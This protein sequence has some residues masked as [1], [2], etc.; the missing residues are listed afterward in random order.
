MTEG[1]TGRQSDSDIE[2]ERKRGDREGHRGGDRER[3]GE[4]EK[5]TAHKMLHCKSNI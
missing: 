3:R 4:R 1:E 2:E 5:I